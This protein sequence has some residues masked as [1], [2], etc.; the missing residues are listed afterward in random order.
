MGWGDTYYQY[1]PGQSFNIT[2]VPNGTYYV[3][4]VANPATNCMSCGTTTGCA[5]AR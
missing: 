3:R 5:C 2:G 4:I 1:L